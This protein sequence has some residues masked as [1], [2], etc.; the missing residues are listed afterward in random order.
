M[1]DGGLDVLKLA[2]VIEKE[3]VS[4]KTRN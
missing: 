2:Q 4:K 1:L 3:S